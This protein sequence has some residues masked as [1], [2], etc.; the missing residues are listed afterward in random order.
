MTEWTRAPLDEI[1]QL[2][3]ERGRYEGWLRA[4]AERRESTPARVYDR[5]QQDYDARLARVL[6][7]LAAH[8][9]VLRDD[10]T[11]LAE[12]HGQEVRLLEE[13]RDALA[14]IELRALVGEYDEPHATRMRAEAEQAIAA[15]EGEAGRMDAELREVRTLLE[16]ATPATAGSAASGTVASD[17]ATPEA[18]ASDR[19]AAAAA[20]PVGG[21]ADGGAPSHHQSVAEPSRTSGARVADDDSMPEADQWA[22]RAPTTG[23][24]RDTT[25]FAPPGHVGR[26]TPIQS[27]PAYAGQGFADAALDAGP[28][29]G[30]GGAG[31]TPEG[32]AA[33][34]TLRCQDCGEMNYPTEWYCE[35]CGG[36]LAAL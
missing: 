3:D 34:K 32:V 28:R 27:A 17:A 6:A 13:Q 33:Q 16:R 35:R 14:E 30:A 22:A 18:F 29:P 19:P 5:V 25:G 23:A 24:A 8:A 11:A 26:D 9:D 4:L 31:D 36:E 2:A 7:T 10:E 20:P 15:R 1:R 21:P 12:R